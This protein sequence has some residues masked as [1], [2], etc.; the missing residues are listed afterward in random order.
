MLVSN[1]VEKLIIITLI[2]NISVKSFVQR[3]STIERTKLKSNVGTDIWESIQSNNDFEGYDCKILGPARVFEHLGDYDFNND[4]KPPVNRLFYLNLGKAMD[5]LRRELP[6]VFY[7]SN[8]DFSIFA[9]QV[10]VVDSCNRKMLVQKTLYAAAV[11]SLKMASVF[12]STAPSMN[13][14]KIEYIEECRTIQCLVDIVLPDTVRLDGQATW[15][16]LFYF[17]LNNDGLIES[18]IF[19]RKLSNFKPKKLSSKEYPWIKSNK[20]K[21]VYEDIP[22]LVPCPVPFSRDFM[23]E[24]QN[25][26]NRQ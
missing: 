18:H 23:S 2:Y 1:I 10:T 4:K 8:L 13:V 20:P 5:S 16:G 15:E 22:D 21:W 25:E 26:S 24:N 3:T 9:N 7:V 6:M 11:K 17:G 12:S 19:D 14:R